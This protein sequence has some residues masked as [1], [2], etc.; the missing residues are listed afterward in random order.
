MFRPFQRC[1]ALRALLLALGVYYSFYDASV[2]LRCAAC[3]PWLAPVAPLQT[4]LTRPLSAGPGQAREAVEELGEGAMPAMD[5][6]GGDAP[7][8]STTFKGTISLQTP[9]GKL[10]VGDSADQVLLASDSSV[11]EAVAPGVG[12]TPGRCM[13][14]SRRASIT[15]MGMGVTT[16]E[17][18]V[19]PEAVKDSSA[20]V[21]V[22]SEDEW[23]PARKSGAFS[24][25]YKLD[26][27][28]SDITNF[29][30][31]NAL[32]P[33]RLMFMKRAIAAVTITIAQDEHGMEFAYSLLG[34]NV[35]ELMVF[36]TV[37][38]DD[39]KPI[40]GLA[41]HFKRD[42]K[43]LTSTKT[44]KFTDAGVEDQRVTNVEWEGEDSAFTQTNLTRWSQQ[45][46]GESVQVTRVINFD[47]DTPWKSQVNDEV[48]VKCSIYLKRVGK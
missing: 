18:A 3:A 36:D 24:G 16:E 9:L 48:E 43:S 28:T 39:D 20:A 10:S 21:E 33:L 37:V 17:L 34:M 32:G 8:E 5:D 6:G 13:Q 45:E 7:V 46:G 38:E 22:P 2:I 30:N 40:R 31:M 47:G 25:R 27:L 12:K 35:S 1:A 44:S 29:F 15:F 19:A 4:S 23:P 42:I 11:A 14:P 41:F 26:M